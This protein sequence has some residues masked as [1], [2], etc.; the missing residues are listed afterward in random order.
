M[1][2]LGRRKMVGT[3]DIEMRYRAASILL[4]PERD[5]IANVPNERYVSGSSVHLRPRA[6]MDVALRVCTGG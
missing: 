3:L 1:V 6:Q 2:G 5:G 4:S